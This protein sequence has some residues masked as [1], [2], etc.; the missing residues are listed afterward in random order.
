MNIVRNVVSIK[1][2]LMY[3]GKFCIA[4]FFVDAKKNYAALVLLA[5]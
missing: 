2:M 1:M 3:S 5:K 4:L